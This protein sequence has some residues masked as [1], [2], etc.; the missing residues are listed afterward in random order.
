MI[1]CFQFFCLIILLATPNIS[2]AADP[3]FTPQVGI[4]GTE[5][6]AGK[7]FT[8]NTKST[9]PI[10]LYIQAIYKYAIG[11][12]GILATV[13]MMVGGIVWLTAGGNPTR[14][15][16]AKAYIGASLTGLIL[17][18]SS[19]L[20]LA[21][22]NPALVNLKESGIAQVA[23]T[24]TGCCSTAT[25]VSINTEAECK[26]VSGTFFSDGEISGSTCVS[27]S[28]IT[29]CCWIEDKGLI[30]TT[31]ICYTNIS[32]ASCK[33]YEKKP[34]SGYTYG[35]FSSYSPECK[36]QNATTGLPCDTIK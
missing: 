13:V 26:N 23:S 8:F 9:K 14:I 22:I 11:I 32:K 2:R 19:Y 24:V 20:I 17:A 5:F 33:E 6:D 12:V 16:E 18:L 7:T 1:F 4:P 31:R 27:S 15:G 10:G 30:E 34:P 36:M 29:G 3:T 25:S 21:T 28:S 35:G